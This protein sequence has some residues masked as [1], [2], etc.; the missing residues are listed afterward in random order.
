[1]QKNRPFLKRIL[2]N[3]TDV[4]S[5]KVSKY[6]N[7][8][9]GVAYILTT[10]LLILSPDSVYNTN[11]SIVAKA[12]TEAAAGAAVVADAHIEEETELATIIQTT[13]DNNDSLG[14][15]NNQLLLMQEG[16]L[17]TR[18]E[19]KILN[20]YNII[21]DREEA[22]AA[23]EQ[24]AIEAEAAAE[25]A[26]EAER[27]AAIE[28]EAEAV[29]QA[30]IEAARIAEEQAAAEAAA[31]AAK[32]SSYPAGNFSNNEIAILER[33]VEA[34]AT[35]G[36]TKSKIIVAN[37]VVN[38]VNNSIFPNS[39]EGVVFQK[40]QFS[41]IRDGRYYSVSITDS[42]KEA[43][44]RALQGEDYSQGALFFANRRGASASNMRWFDNNLTYLFQ[45]GGHEYFR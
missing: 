6:K 43:V 28:A 4:F 3:L 7:S 29:R 38:R 25:A 14:S 8:T 12:A 44:S 34:E 40:S 15:E 42:T 26:A 22:A 33:I 32:A 10:T 1:M 24:A 27:L 23:E 19:E 31:I 37:V 21:I 30:E 2:G 17:E 13:N 41:P 39:I 16:S 36:D 35:G 5:V 9:I 11:G 45:H 18:L 20:D